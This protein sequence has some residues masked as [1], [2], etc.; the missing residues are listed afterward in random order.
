MCGRF[1]LNA[2][3]QDV[4]R[5]F[6]LSSIPLLTPRYNIA[7]TQ[8]VAA[9]REAVNGA[10]RELVELRWG[11][12][13]FWAESPRG[14]ARM[15]NARSETA[16]TRPAFRGAFRARRC[17]LPASG[18]YEWQRRGARKQP[19]YICRRDR[20]PFAMAGLWERWDKQ[21]EPLESCTVLTTEANAVVQPLHDRMP[22]IVGS[23]GFEDWLD[24][25]HDVEALGRLLRPFPAEELTAYPVSL[26]VNSP[27]ND[28]AKLIEPMATGALFD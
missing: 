23:E 12:V 2:P 4:A 16:A 22:V 11:L 20:A 9:V 10:G 28:D 3:P 5:L 15:I 14:A 17:L 25:E 1:T 6:G 27:K 18:F 7:P 21:G 26:L 13:P 8:S 19:Y 24:P